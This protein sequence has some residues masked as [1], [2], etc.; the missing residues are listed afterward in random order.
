MAI[1]YV[2]GITVPDLAD[3]EIWKL[4][5]LDLN[6]AGIQVHSQKGHD[7]VLLLE[8]SIE[9]NNETH[10][11]GAFQSIPVV[12]DAEI[13]VSAPCRIPIKKWDLASLDLGAAGQQLFAETGLGIYLRGV[14]NEQLVALEDICNS[15]I[16]DAHSRLQSYHDIDV[17][18]QQFAFRELGSRGKQRFDLILPE[19]NPAIGQVVQSGPWVPLIRQVLNLTD[20][21]TPLPCLVSVVYSLPGAD[22]QSWHADGP[23]SRP[24]SRPYA[25]C[26]FL[27]LIDLTCETGFTQFWPG[28]HT[29][30]GLLGFG[31]AAEVCGATVDGMVSK[32]DAVIYDYGLLH[33]G[34]GNTSNMRRP[35]VQ[36]VYHVPGWQDRKNYGRESLFA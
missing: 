24:P 13:Y 34:M 10:L 11:L 33:R 5:S 30:A 25:V 21:A 1:Y 20:T 9:N 19:N 14:S 16:A 28:S 29:D 2:L 7:G 17:G 26:V 8:C 18:S 6:N 4:P 3:Q 23:P 27:P 31:P 12:S 35:V 36:M 22:T 32:G 15:R